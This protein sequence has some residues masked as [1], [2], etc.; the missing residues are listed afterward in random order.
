MEK[1]LTSSPKIIREHSI[2]SDNYMSV[3]LPTEWLKARDKRRVRKVEIVHNSDDTLTIRK[4]G[5]A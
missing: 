2:P 1:D 4:K 3:N 5:V